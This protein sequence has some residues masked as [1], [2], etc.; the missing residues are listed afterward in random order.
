MSTHWPS[1]ISKSARSAARLLNGGTRLPCRESRS[2]TSSPASLE[3]GPIRSVILTW[4][5]A[6]PGTR[7]TCASR[8][9]RC[10][11]PRS[12]CSV[13][14]HIIAESSSSTAWSSH[15]K[16]GRPR[17]DSDSGSVH[18]PSAWSI[19]ETTSSLVVIGTAPCGPPQS[20]MRTRTTR[21]ASSTARAG[22]PALLH[23]STC[24]TASSTS[25]AFMRPSRCA[26]QIVGPAGAVTPRIVST[27]SACTP[28]TH[29]T[30]DPVW[31]R[32][33]GTAGKSVQATAARQRSGCASMSTDSWT[34][35]RSVSSRSSTWHGSHHDAA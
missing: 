35:P 13:P 8:N 32:V 29:A 34:M 24:P 20:A 33:S 22:R 19:S 11:Y 6:R 2:M 7:R 15:S 31:T 14:C 25:T 10:R 9:S 30:S 21:I 1:R 4:T 12:R 16:G 23:A 3:R 5:A 27:R 26:N 17:E 28:S 18:S